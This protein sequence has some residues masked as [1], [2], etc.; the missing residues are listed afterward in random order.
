MIVSYNIR[1]ILH[2]IFL[3]YIE[4]QVAI[5]LKVHISFQGMERR[6][7]AEPLFTSWRHNST[8]AS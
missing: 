7:E 8:R 6:D 4:L 5:Y 3:F 1:I 2:Y